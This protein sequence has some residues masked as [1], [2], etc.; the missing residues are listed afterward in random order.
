MKKECGRK[1]RQGGE[2]GGA[3]REASLKEVA[4]AGGWL[5]VKNSGR[6]GRGG[7]EGEREDGQEEAEVV[8]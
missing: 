4:V 6:H 8:K 1:S 3:E 5:R 2:R 7:N